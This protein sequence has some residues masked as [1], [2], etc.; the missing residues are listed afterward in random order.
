MDWTSL[1]EF[2][3]LLANF[4]WWQS[5]LFL[6]IFMIITLVVKGFGPKIKF[7]LQSCFDSMPETLHYRMF[8]GLITDVLHVRMKNEFRR[9][10]KENGF[11]HLSGNEFSIY[12]KDKSKNIM[13]LLKNHIINLYPPNNNKMF[14]KMEEIIE[15]FDKKSPDIEDILFEI[16][17]EAKKW[18]QYEEAT[19][20]NIDEKFEEEI[21]KFIKKPHTGDCKTCLVVLFGKREITEN[22]KKQIQTL[23]NQMNFVEQKL[24]QIQ[25]DF[26]NFYSQKLNNKT[27]GQ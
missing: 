22:K 27:G 21:E 3:K 11:A 26:L 24:E 25:S 16:F 13:S 15:H 18:V 23:K 2:W 5:L 10:F 20:L 19:L 7:W 14:V 12:V 1:N 6:T 8:A 17:I 9:M 4:E